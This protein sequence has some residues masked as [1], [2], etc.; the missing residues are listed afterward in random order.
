VKELTKKQTEVLDYIKIYIAEHGYPPA[1]REIG[2]GLGLSSPATVHNHVKKLEE[3]GAIKTANSKFRTIELLVENEYLKK[4]EELTK[5]PLLNEIKTNPAEEIENPHEFF[6]LP[7]AIIPKKEKLFVLKVSDDAMIKK[8]IYDGDYVIVQKQNTAKNGDIV[9]LYLEDNKVTLNTFYKE[10]DHIR[11]QSEN[12]KI[13]PII[14]NN[15]T[16]LGKV[17]GLYRKL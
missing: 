8:G 17:I 1:I 16:I 6:Y 12:D 13:A 2:A 15:W 5:V 7:T 3:A 14:L 4:D 10:E 9:A 11:L